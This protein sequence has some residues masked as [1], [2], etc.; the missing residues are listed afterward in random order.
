MES[1]DKKIVLQNL[2]R[3]ERAI[4]ESRDT[5]KS[6]ISWWL[7]ILLISPI[8]LG[9]YSIV[10]FFQRINRRDRHFARINGLFK[11]AL[12]ITKEVADEKELDIHNE[13]TDIEQILK[14]AENTFLK[15][16]GAFL[17]ILEERWLIFNSSLF[18]E[19]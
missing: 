3:L 16:K 1:I 15:P 6:L 11:A 12:D 13:V 4:K 7:Y 18:S 19:V 17:P 2:P 9:I 10:V 8:T 5:D 14:N